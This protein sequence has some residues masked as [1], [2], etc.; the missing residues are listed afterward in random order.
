MKISQERI[1]Y[2][3]QNQESVY[4]LHICKKQKGFL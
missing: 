4:F 3:I 1:M 2:I